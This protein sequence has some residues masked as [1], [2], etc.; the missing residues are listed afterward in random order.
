MKRLPLVKGLFGSDEEVRKKIR[1]L[2]EKVACFRKLP[3]HQVL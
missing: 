3:E 1:M 2:I